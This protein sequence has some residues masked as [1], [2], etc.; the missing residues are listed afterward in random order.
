MCAVCGV[1]LCLGCS[2]KVKLYVT[3]L[4]HR[5][6]KAILGH[7]DGN[8]VIMSKILM[9][10]N[11]N[12]NDVIVISCCKGEEINW[13]KIFLQKCHYCLQF[14]Q[15]SIWNCLRLYCLH[16]TLFTSRDLSIIESSLVSRLGKL[17]IGDTKQ[18]FTL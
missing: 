9:G 18:D 2:L 12:T 14:A 13:F 17:N 11:G 7:M 1:R 5:W 4:F 3:D 6:I 8:Y 15:F 10:L 16:F